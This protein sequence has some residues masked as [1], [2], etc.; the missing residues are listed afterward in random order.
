MILSNKQCS[1]ILKQLYQDKVT[2]RQQILA[3]RNCTLSLLMLDAGLRITELVELFIYDLIVEGMNQSRTAVGT[4]NIVR[5]IPTGRFPRS[6]PL[7]NRVRNFIE[8]MNQWWWTSNAGRSG[9]F[10][11]YN[12]TASRHITTRQVQRII[13]QASLDALGHSIRPNDLRRTCAAKLLQGMEL[14]SVQ[15]FLGYKTNQKS[16]FYSR[17]NNRET[18]NARA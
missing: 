14:K 12:Q 1:L 7:T 15:N 18:A 16:F 6:I 3:L 4:L 2:Q 10:A 5:G 17:K 9:S 8:Q 11:F 13:G